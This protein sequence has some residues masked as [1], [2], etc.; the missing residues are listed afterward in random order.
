MGIVRLV[1]RTI[2]TP[3]AEVTVGGIGNVCTL[4]GA[5]ATGAAR[6]C[7][8]ATAEYLTA[9]GKTDFGLLFTGEKIRRYY[10]R[11][12]WKIVENKITFLTE[13]GEPTTAGHEHAM[14]HPGT[15]PVEDWP[16]GDIDLNGPD[17]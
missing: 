3:A 4:P 17:W 1:H 5:H 16:E 8:K 15:R 6:E 7:M 2:I 10:R 13:Q 11:L 12:G 9:S 14:I